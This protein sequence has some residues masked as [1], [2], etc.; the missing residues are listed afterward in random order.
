MIKFS[1]P[2]GRILLLG[3]FS[4]PSL[5]PALGLSPPFSPTRTSGPA[6]P[7]T[8]H[9]C[10]LPRRDRE[11]EGESFLSLSLSPRAFPAQGMGTGALRPYPRSAPKV[12]KGGAATTF[13]SG[14]VGRGTRSHE[15][16]TD[17]TRPLARRLAPYGL[18]DQLEHAGKPPTTISSP[19][20]MSRSSKYRRRRYL[21]GEPPHRGY[22]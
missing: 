13:K 6:S 10:P 11:R 22:K 3:P 16:A 9:L 21:P 7:A 12:K 4:S 14:E 2:L 19:P 17:L 15:L 8:P 20:F 18:L 5:F 1:F